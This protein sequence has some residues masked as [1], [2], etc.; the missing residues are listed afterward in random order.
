MKKVKSI[1]DRFHTVTPYLI[2]DDANGL[3]DFIKNAFNGEVTF[4]QR[5]DSNRVMHATARIGNSSIMISDTGPGMEVIN[6]ML[7][8]YTD[9]VDA[10]FSQA[11]KAKAEI[12]QE[13][14]NEF[15]GDRAACLK[16]SWGN[17]WWIAT[18]VEDVNHDELERRARESRPQ[19]IEH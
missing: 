8:I 14:K 17:T 5:T 16:D 4:M 13:P 18:H 3:I 10:M 6:A 1:P 19:E 15:Y 12:V 9:D 7:Y 2:V 11:A